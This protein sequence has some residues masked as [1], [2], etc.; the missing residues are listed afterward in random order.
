[1]QL[2]SGSHIPD[3]LLAANALLSEKLHQGFAA[4]KITLHQ[5]FGVSISST[6]LG[7]ISPLYDDGTASRY[8]GKERDSES[9]LDDFG[10]RY[11]ASIQG[12]F[13][14]P[15]WAARPTAVPYALFG[16]PQSLNLYTY[17]RN[18]PVTQADAD[19]HDPDQS[20]KDAPQPSGCDDGP[21]SGCKA[22][23]Q[24]SQDAPNSTAAQNNNNQKP[25]KL[26]SR[27]RV[28]GYSRQVQPLLILG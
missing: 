12:R 5:G 28:E 19:G 7:I 1:M 17:V 3:G 10:A 2:A 20:N 15:D 18:D 4:P 11:F 21:G 8:T 25:N 14:S 24:S 13:L 6:P 26:N 9:G 27:R 23:V 16:D 22:V